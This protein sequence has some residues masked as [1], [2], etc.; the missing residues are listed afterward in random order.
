MKQI[1]A[2]ICALLLLTG[3]ASNSM[4]ESFHENTG[5][6]IFNV[7]TSYFDNY[8][9]EQTDTAYIITGRV[10]QKND[11][12]AIVINIHAEESKTVNVSGTLTK[13]SGDDIELVYVPED[14]EEVKIADNASTSYDAAITIS[15]GDGRII[16]MGENA[17]YDFEIELELTDGVSYSDL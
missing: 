5:S 14:G 15:K 16:F 9:H 10:I 17:V 4:D 13:V 7:D 1:I 3:C 2:S 11:E 6:K 12:N 8:T